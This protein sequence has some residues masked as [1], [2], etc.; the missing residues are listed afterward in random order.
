MDEGWSKAKSA[1]EAQ[2]AVT[3]AHSVLVGKL[4]EVMTIRSRFLLQ[5]LFYTFV[6]PLTI[7]LLVLTLIPPVH[8]LISVF[9]CITAIPLAE[10]VSSAF[11]AHTRTKQR[12]ELGAH[13][14]PRV[15]GRLP[16]NIDILWQLIYGESTEYCANTLRRWA[17]E[18]GP[19][20]DMNILWSHQVG[21]PHE[22]SPASN[23]LTVRT[24]IDNHYGS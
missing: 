12:A 8:P 14:I 21:R 15:H 2:E 18:Y 5:S 7:S 9:L 20:Y 11:T 13:V 3:G 6:L 10:I 17:D 4:A 24:H 22:Q 19:T 16:G 1:V 23:Q